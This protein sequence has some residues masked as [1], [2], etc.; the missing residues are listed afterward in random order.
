M[1]LMTKQ[2]QKKEIIEKA[3]QEFEEQLEEW[4]GADE[5]D[6]LDFLTDDDWYEDMED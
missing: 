2:E 4:F 3:M 5:D 1:Y 6:D